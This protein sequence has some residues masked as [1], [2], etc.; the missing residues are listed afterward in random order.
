MGGGRI[1]Y[2]GS[3]SYGILITGG[4]WF[5]AMTSVPSVLLSRVVIAGIV[6]IQNARTN[7]SIGKYWI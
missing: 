6:C 1:H 7:V 3:V 5:A 4:V 2:Q